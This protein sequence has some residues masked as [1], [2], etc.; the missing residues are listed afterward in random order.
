[1]AATTMV[2]WA[3]FAIAI[4][5]DPATRATMLAREMDMSFLSGLKRSFSIR[6]RLVSGSIVVN[7]TTFKKLD[8]T[9]AINIYVRWS[10]VED[11][12]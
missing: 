7:K 9:I 6:K 11:G 8:Q 2:D 3:C 5:K 12:S 4:P 1:M 10:A